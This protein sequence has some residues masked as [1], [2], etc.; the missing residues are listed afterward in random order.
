MACYLQT[1]PFLDL[2]VHLYYMSIV[3]IELRGVLSNIKYIRIVTLR[4]IRQKYML[5]GSIWH[6]FIDNTAIIA[7]DVLS[8]LQPTATE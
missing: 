5:S 8:G 6:Y 4:A 1:T 3:L 2:S 7:I